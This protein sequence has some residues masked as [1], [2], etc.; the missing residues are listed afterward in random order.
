MAIHHI[1]T[2]LTPEAVSGL[3]TGDEVLLSGTIYTARDQA[4][5]RLCVL[6]D[7]GEALPIDLKG[8]IIYFAG[9]TPTPPGK[10][11]GSVGPTT[12][13][14]MDAFSPKLIRAGLKGM[15]GKGSRSPEV[16][17]AMKSNGA[18]YFAATGGA[19]ALIA[20][21]VKSSTC[22]A[23]Q[24]LGPEAIYKME[25]QDFPL[26]VAIDSKGEN[27][28]IRGPEEYRKQT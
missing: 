5:S 2:P 9:P 21:R 16:I 18:V 8:T 6:L 19:G 14:R 23:Y 7:K 12:S 27:L 28:Y 22:V 15:I 13:G 25:V 10:A 11:V 1:Q 20:Q 17:E 3:S 26:V 24:E 4:H